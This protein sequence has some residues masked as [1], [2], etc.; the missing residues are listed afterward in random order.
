MESPIIIE[1]VKQP[2]R[3]RRQPASAHQIAVNRANAA[4]STGPNTPEGKASSS[5]NAIKH[6]LAASRFTV[7]RVE[8]PAQLQELR[9]NLL[10]C[11]RPV[12]T[13]EIEALDCM[14]RAQ[15]SMRRAAQLEASLFTT[16]INDAWADPR[17]RMEPELEQNI[18]VSVDQNRGFYLA[19]GIRMLAKESNGLS[20]LLRYQAHAERQYRRALE[21]FERLK[22]LR[23][24][25][26]N[27]PISDTPFPDELKRNEVVVPGGADAPVGAG[28]PGGAGGL[29]HR[30]SEPPP[31]GGAGAPGGAGGLCY[32]PSDAAGGTG[33]PGGADAAGGAG[34]PGGAGGLCHRP[35]DAP[36]GADTPG[37]PVVSATAH[38]TLVAPPTPSPDAGS[39]A[40]DSRVRYIKGLQRETETLFRSDERRRGTAS[41]GSRLR[42]AIRF[43][44]CA[45]RTA[46]WSG[47]TRNSRAIRSWP[48]ARRRMRP[49]RI[50]RQPSANIYKRV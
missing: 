5:Q 10:H 25:M 8:D 35:S 30:P 18:S 45:W 17:V 50:R 36:G 24:E 34:A 3:R 47:I 42:P 11:Y 37:G 48:T 32:R 27:E 40:P 9:A 14:A 29:C 13:Q 43:W 39:P 12:N 38:P 20:L 41:A 49:T 1:S 19:E 21:E 44:R 26:P 22:K 23:A 33:A 28:A 16:S 31:A 15:F 46:E 6:G 7:V 2:K 4:R